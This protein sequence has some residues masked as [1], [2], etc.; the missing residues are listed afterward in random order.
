MRS[1]GLLRPEDK[2]SALQRA[3][4]LLA[5][6]PTAVEREQYIAPFAAVFGTT[7]TALKED[8][9]RVLSGNAAPVRTAP[10]ASAERAPPA[11]SF[12]SP[13]EIAL[14]LFALYPR[15]RKLLAELIVPDDA[16]GSAL[17]EVLKNA[18]EGDVVVAVHAGKDGVGALHSLT[19]LPAGLAGSLQAAKSLPPEHAERLS[20]LLLFCE[21]HGFHEWSESLAASEIRHNCQQANRAT[22]I[23]KQRDITAKLSAARREGK[24]LE[25]AHL[26]T[27]YLQILKLS[28]MAG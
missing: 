16:F 7:E 2:R 23:T 20:V 15:L 28:K 17:Y 21:Q 19:S 14:A 12:F 4:R 5:A 26:Q 9:T 25:E 18:G 6:L 13:A 8:L 22:I 1:A 3:L 27:Q 11:V 24:A 10:P